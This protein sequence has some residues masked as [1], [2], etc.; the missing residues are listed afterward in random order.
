VS[1]V[2]LLRRNPVLREGADRVLREIAAKSEIRFFDKG[3]P[4]VA[5]G[6]PQTHVLFVAEGQLRLYRLNREAETQI[7]VGVLDP[8]A[9]FGDAELYGGARWSVSA[10]AER[11]TTIVAMP[12]ASFDRMIASDGRISAG[13][14]RD[15]CARHL[16]AVQIMQVLALQKTQHQILRLLWDLAP[17][18][19]VAGGARVAPLSQVRL[20]KA[21]GAN[22]KTIARN[23]KDLEDAGLIRREGKDSVELLIAEDV[24][25]WGSLSKHG[26]G[27]SWRLPGDLDDPGED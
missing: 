9:I 21:I 18:S 25:F 5:A 11:P 4:I 14:Y 24:V 26:F 15:A 7:L 3:A 13:L 12:N 1:V 2:A 17:R 6:S 27:A 8:P 20:A 10:R 23:L 19:E 22:R 16:L